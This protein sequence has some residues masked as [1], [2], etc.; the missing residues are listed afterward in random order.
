MFVS[1]MRWTAVPLA[2]AIA[3]CQIPAPVG[4]P[5][6]SQEDV[7]ALDA[8]R[9]E[10]IQATLAGAWA[11]LAA[12]YAENAVRMPP[13]EV[14]V[15]GREAIQQA[16]EAEPGIT[17]EFTITSEET[18]GLGDLA[19]QKGTYSVTMTVE[20][21]PEPIS[22]TGKYLVIVRKQPDGSWLMA[23]HIWNSDR[24]LAELVAQTA[25]QANSG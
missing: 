4:P 14:A 10:F 17:T 13:N 18:T 20:G 12:L 16:F 6:L 11:D 19:Y 15:Q 3:A 25:G 24:P 23:E 8:L 7:A 21:L 2:L 22:D 1:S 5:G 9:D